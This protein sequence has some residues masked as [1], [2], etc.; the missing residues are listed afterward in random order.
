VQRLGFGSADVEQ[1]APLQAVRL[2]P[3]R[4]ESPYSSSVADRIRHAYGRSYPDTIRALRGHFEHPPDAVAFPASEVEIEAAL[5]WAASANVAVIP[6]GGGT[7]VVGGVEPIVPDR[8]D[9]VLSLDLSRMKRVLEVDEV[10][11]SALIEAGA[12]GPELERQLATRGLTMRFYPQSFELASLGGMIAT[13]AG[14]HFATLQ[15]HIDELVQA[16]RAI[17]PAGEWESRRLPGS[18]AGPA[19]DRLLIG[20]EG[21]LGVIASAWMRVRARPASRASR[22]VAF[23][24]FAVGAEAVR[25]LS[26]SGL[27]PSNCRLVDGLEAEMTGLGDG[28]GALLVLGFESGDDGY[29]VQAL[30]TRALAI[31][32]AHGGRAEPP[33]G[34]PAGTADASRSGGEPSRRDGS[35]A[36]S[37]APGG[38]PN[39]GGH[40]A[41]SGW[42]AAFLA[43]PYLRDALVQCG[44]LCDTFETAVTWERF[45]AFHESVLT[46]TRESLPQPRRVSCRLTHVYA[47]GP[48]PYYT[49]LAPARRGH[50]LEQWQAMKVTAS[51]AILAGGG[52]IT[53]HHA[54]GRDHMPWYER[55]RPQPF[56]LALSAAKSALD[57]AGIL[58]P[59]VLIG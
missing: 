43:M 9:G 13:R 5:E 21:T 24:S 45:P 28:G 26:Q 6:Y 57:P 8:F 15:T 31:C 2:P 12:N 11:R 27:N 10:S 22:A 48:A 35:P 47:D 50:E 16:I 34:T 40:D 17:A 18:G 1:P 55:Q 49:V 25:V 3:P 19:P 58:N 30:L 42:R 54:V 37:P 7:S 52:T 53:H 36:G 41:V 38:D 29:P 46:A 20:S 56:A 4:V 51:D 14:G 39:G 33:A 23:D 44:V 32:A 59:G